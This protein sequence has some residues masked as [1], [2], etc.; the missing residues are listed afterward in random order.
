EAQAVAELVELLGPEEVSLDE[1]GDRLRLDL[2][3]LGF[4]VIRDRPL[5]VT[6][7]SRDYDLFVNVSFLSGSPAAPDVDSVYVVHFP[8]ELDADLNLVQKA[9]IRLLGPVVQRTNPIDTA[10]GEGFYPR[11]GGRPRHFWTNGD[12]RVRITPDPDDD[13]E[14][15]LVF[16]RRHPP[17]SPPL[18][19]VVERGGEAV[20]RLEVGPGDSRL[21]RRRGIPVTVPVPADPAMVDVEIAIRSETFVPAEVLGGDDDRDLGVAL[22]ALHIGSGRLDRFGARLGALFP[23]L[24]RTAADHDFLDSYD[25]VVCNSEFTRSWLRRWWDHDGE[26]LHPPVRM[27]AAA[28]DKQPVILAVGRF[29]GSDSGHSKKQLE[30]VVGV[31]EVVVGGGPLQEREQ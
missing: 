19:V 29:F 10:W 3:G 31:E 2:S 14:L 6:A 9:A 21:D 28:G 5:A 25:H 12:G 22:T 13:L 30:L 8:A 15:R 1:L 4:R 26:V 18:E 20:T 27:H 11:E 24:Q 7:A 16:A 23:F 17:G